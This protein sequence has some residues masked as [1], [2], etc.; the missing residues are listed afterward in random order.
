MFAPDQPRAAAELV[1][2]CRPGG[3]IAMANWTPEGF[4]G[5]LFRV[6]GRHVP[7]A[8]GLRSPS[9]W[10]SEDGLR[11]LFGGAVSEIRT[12]RRMFNFRYHSAA[13]WIEIFRSWYGPVHRAF[14]AL[15]DAGKAAL[16]RD[17][18]QL[19]AKFDTSGGSS[20]VAPGEYLEVVIRR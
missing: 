19:L 3:V 8:P 17:L 16:E 15:D 18:M 4:I 1:R 20:L 6:I 13:H 2:V 7:P 5:E 9:Y 12:N 14:A 10:G 11:D